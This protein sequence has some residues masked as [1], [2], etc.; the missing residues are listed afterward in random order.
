[1][2]K[3]KVNGAVKHT[4]SRGKPGH[5]GAGINNCERIICEHIS[6]CLSFF[7]CRLRMKIA[8]TLKG[9]CEEQSDNVGKVL[10]SVPS[11]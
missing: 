5:H 11:A 10:S 8:F 2:A 3:P 1:M 4:P 7:I 6:L 9:A